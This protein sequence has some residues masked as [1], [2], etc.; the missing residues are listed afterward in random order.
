MIP[1]KTYAITHCYTDMNKG[2]AAI[3]QS[4]I[5]LLRRCDPNGIIHLYSTFGPKDQRFLDEHDHIKGLAD[6]LYPAILSTPEKLAWLPIEASRAL[7]FL[8]NFLQ[9]LLLLVTINPRWVSIFARGRQAEGIH[10]L[11]KADVIISKG[12]SYLTTQNLSI[13]QAISLFTMLYPFVFALRYRRPCVIFSQS[14]GPVNGRFNQFLFHQILK[15]I[16][17]IYVREN[18]CIE[19][20][21]C[22]RDLNMVNPMEC[23]PDTAFYYESPAPE[24][25]G[26]IGYKSVLDSF[27][28]NRLKVGLTI[29]DHA[30][31]YVSNSDHRIAHMDAYVASI[32]AMIC[33]LRKQYDAQVHIFPQVTVSN[34]HKGHNDVVLSRS[35][36]AE[37]ASSEPD[38]VIFHEYNFSPVELRELYRSMDV[39]VGTRLH[40]VIFAVSTGV[41]SINIAYHGTK[42]KGIF[43]GFEPLCDNV[44]AIDEITPDDLIY[45]IDKLIYQ[46]DKTR[47]SIILEISTITPK[48]TFA[49]RQVVKLAE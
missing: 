8:I 2:D 7:P 3:I 4:T 14:L 41:P 39:F 49:M 9:S 26:S 1:S 45:K 15:R 40:S 43:E 48:L 19:E 34:S 29:V 25:F 23:I 37:F 31:K 22:V 12:G 42:S 44:I 27:D 6:E 30:F 13:R 20:Y 35:V 28:P 5:Q 24:W 33:H 11:A 18:L 17:K 32:R 38:S 16:S 36:A 21:K 10:N 46:R 47:S